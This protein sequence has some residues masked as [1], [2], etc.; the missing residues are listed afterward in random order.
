MNRTKDSG[1]LHEQVVQSPS[2]VL[3]LHHC[4]P[5]A[6]LYGHPRGLLQP[7]SRVLQMGQFCSACSGYKLKVGSS[8]T[9]TLKHSKTVRTGVQEVHLDVHFEKA[10]SSRLEYI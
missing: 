6:H 8:C 10:S 5:S 9:K 4:P 2:S 1:K 3:L 7:D